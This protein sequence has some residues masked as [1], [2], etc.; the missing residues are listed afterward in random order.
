MGPMRVVMPH[1]FV[2]NMQQMALVPDQ[3]P[4]QQFVAAALDPPFHD[5]IHSGRPDAAEHNLDAYVGEDLVEQGGE[6]AV[7]IADEVPRFAAGVVQ[8][9]GEIP[10]RLGDP[11]GGG[12]RGGV[13]AARVSIRSR[14]ALSKVVPLPRAGRR[15]GSVVHGAE[16]P[17]R[18][19]A[20][21]DTGR[22]S[23]PCGCDGTPWI[24]CPTYRQRCDVELPPL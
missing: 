7:A 6:L 13:E 15:A 12:M 24:V 19:C 23:A 5:G 21:Y 9:H 14:P 4:V 3:R 22:R 16:L 10:H 1:V 11:D 18:V 20:A 2:Q 17:C 8:V